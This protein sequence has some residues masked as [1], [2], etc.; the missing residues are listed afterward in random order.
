MLVVN[1]TDLADLVGA[2][3]DVMAADAGKMR[4]AGPSVFA[5]IKNGE[6][7]DEIAAFI[8]AASR[9]AMD[10]STVAEGGN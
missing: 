9:R 4:G 7:V 8:L 10:K 1:K 5:C 6:G 2:D 3:L